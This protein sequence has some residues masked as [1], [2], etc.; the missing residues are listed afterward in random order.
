[1][2]LVLPLGVEVSK[3]QATRQEMQGLANMMQDLRAVADWYPDLADAYNMLGMARVEGGGINSALE[4]QRLAIALSPRNIEYQ[5]NLG[6]IYVA[7]KKWELA[8]E[9]FTRLKEGTDRAAAAAAKQQL[10][11]L[12]TLQ[13]YGVRPQRAGEG[14]TPAGAASTP[15]AARPLRPCPRKRGRIKKVQD[16]DDDR[17][18]SRRQSSR[19]DRAH[20]ISEGQDRE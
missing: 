16:D 17:H 9:V 13:K 11:D 5:F 4:A 8:R 19:D 1:V 7:G 14:E 18:R 15:G 6:Q 10:E 20:A 2:D 12:D 3:A